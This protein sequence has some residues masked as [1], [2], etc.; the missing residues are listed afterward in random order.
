M[1]YSFRSRDIIY[2]AVLLFVLLVPLARYYASTPWVNDCVLEY[3]DNME[4][5]WYRGITYN[6][7]WINHIEASNSNMVNS[8]KEYETWRAYGCIITGSNILNNLNNT[9]Y[10]TI[11]YMIR[12][13][14]IYEKTKQPLALLN[15]YQIFQ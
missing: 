10:C 8:L 6:I 3:V 13:A 15:N 9:F 4:E 12:K 1:K 5:A 14:P 11:S 7:N 2:P